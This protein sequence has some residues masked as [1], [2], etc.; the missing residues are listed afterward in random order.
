[1]PKTREQIE[2]EIKSK[3]YK[4]QAAWT[5]YLAIEK[6]YFAGEKYLADRKAD[7]YFAYQNMSNQERPKI[8]KLEAELDEYDRIHNA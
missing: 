1:M 6:R 2:S 7:L 4:L 5:E 8:E 3:E